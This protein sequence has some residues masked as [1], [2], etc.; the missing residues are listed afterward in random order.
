M[1]LICTTENLDL[2]FYD[3]RLDEIHPNA[4]TGL[5][6]EKL[7]LFEAGLQTMPYFRGASYHT[8]HLDLSDNH[9]KVIPI[10]YFAGNFSKLETLLITH[11]EIEMIPD[12]S[13]L[14]HSLFRLDFKYNR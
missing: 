7:C 4:F 3:V 13:C 14:A 12:L 10:D 11:N 9:I 8:R 1:N 2:L 6:L 5:N